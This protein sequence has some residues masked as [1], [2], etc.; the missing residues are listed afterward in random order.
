MLICHFACCAHCL[1]FVE[2]SLHDSR[3]HSTRFENLR[4]ARRVLSVADPHLLAVGCGRGTGVL[5]HCPVGV[6]T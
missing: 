5:F 2:L 1:G 4:R 3:R 6:E